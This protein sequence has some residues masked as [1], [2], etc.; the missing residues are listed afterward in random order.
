MEADDTDLDTQ[1]ALTDD[2]IEQ[3]LKEAAEGRTD[4]IMQNLLNNTLLGR[5]VKGIGNLFQTIVNPKDSKFYRGVS[6]EDLAGIGGTLFGYT[7][8]ELNKMNALGGFYSEPMREF[9]RR[10]NRISNMLR[11]GAAGKRFSQGNLDNLLGQFGF[12]DE[13]DT[14][15]MMKSIRESSKTGFGVGDVGGGDTGLGA[16]G[17]GRDYSQSPGAMAGDMEYGEE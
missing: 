5:T 14:A 12:G 8:D 13:V 11:R 9:R 1:A 7:P 4:G 17:G 16:G 6:K 10:S 3:Q 2:I 15:G